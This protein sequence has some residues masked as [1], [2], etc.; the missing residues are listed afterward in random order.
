M[1]FTTGSRDTRLKNK[2]SRLTQDWYPMV[3]MSTY[4][5][6][7]GCHSRADLYS[8]SAFSHSVGVTFSLAMGEESLIVIVHSY[9][10]SFPFHTGFLIHRC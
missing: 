10:M 9:F 8:F 7:S 4:G 6:I 5:Q 2:F 1:R 3:D